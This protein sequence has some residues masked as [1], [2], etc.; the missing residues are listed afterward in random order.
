M[1]SLLDRLAEAH[2]YCCSAR[3][4]LND[5]TTMLSL[6]PGDIAEI[7]KVAVALAKLSDKVL[8]LKLKRKTRGRLSSPQS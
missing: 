6:T 4:I 2:Y 7:K 3:N 5:A 8:Q 1:A